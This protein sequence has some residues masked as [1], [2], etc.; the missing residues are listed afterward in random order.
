[1]AERVRRLT[2]PRVYPRVDIA[3]SEA[4]ELIVGLSMITGTDENFDVGSAWFHEVRTKMSSDLARLVALLQ[5]GE[6]AWHTVWHTLLAAV[7]DAPTC[8]PGFAQHLE[9][10]PT[11]ELWLQ[12]LGFHDLLDPAPEVRDA[13]LAAGRGLVE[14]LERWFERDQSRSGR[15]VNGLARALGGDAPGARRLILDLLAR[16]H[17][18]VFTALWAEVAPVLERDAE[19]KRRLAAHRRPDELVEEATNGG[20]YV[21]EAGISRLLLVPTYLGRPWVSLNRQRDTL[22]LVHP[23]GDGALADSPEEARRQRVLRLAKALSDDTRLRALR[24]MAGSSRSLQELADELGIRKSTMHHHLA[25]LRAA[26]LLRLRFFEKRYSLR[27]TPLT[28]MSGLLGEYLGEGR[29][30]P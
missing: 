9:A 6:P 12:M 28:E 26:G 19:E 17:E 11:D 23:V 29:K 10:M 2:P 1:M 13:M 4:A 25:V 18:E 3:V 21:P 5:G 27:T 8:M 15:S 16:W 22:V 20:E 14:P 30:R 7:A 24:L